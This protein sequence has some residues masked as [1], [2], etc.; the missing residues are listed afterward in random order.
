MWPNHTFRAM[1]SQIALWLEADLAVAQAA[2][3][4]VE[5]LF[6]R[7]EQALSRFRASSELSQLN[8]RCQQWVSVSDLLW[9]VL[10]QALT[11]AENT[12]GLFDP[13]ILAALESVGYWQSFDQLK[14][15]N[16]YEPTTPKPFIRNGWQ[17]IQLDPL[18][19]AV[20][21]PAGIY[22]D[23]G[24]IAKGYSAQQA[25]NL[26]AQFG[27]CLVDAGGD[28]TAGWAPQGYPGWPVAIAAPWQKSD[29]VQENLAEV[30]LA[31]ATLATSGVDY[32]RWQYN[33][34]QAHHLIDPRTG[35]PAN[36]D[37]ITATVLAKDAVIAD[38]WAT[39]VLILGSQAGLQ[40]LNQQP[41]LAGCLVTTDHTFH[42][43]E[44]MQE[45]TRF[46]S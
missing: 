14:L 21:L 4:Q 45:M 19:Q 3:T 31:E 11:W 6:I 42:Q 16:P 27:P 30:W 24:G 34:R 7:N 1:G 13:T 25:V 38:V 35:Q 41:Q 23:F 37:I 46:L 28:L 12:N 22:L 26:L 44:Q 20:W 17:A 40:Q 2:F 9:Q 33:G 43:T 39:A 18:Q 15:S 8:G 29:M 5:Q 10:V 36:S 32:R